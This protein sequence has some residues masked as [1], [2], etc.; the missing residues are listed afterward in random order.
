MEFPKGHVCKKIKNESFGSSP[1]G[2]HERFPWLGSSYMK[3]TLNLLSWASNYFVLCPQLPRVF[4]N[5]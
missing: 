5:T 1:G 3:D 2:N 4:G